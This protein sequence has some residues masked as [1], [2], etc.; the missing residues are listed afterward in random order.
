MRITASDTFEVEGVLLREVMAVNVVSLMKFAI[1]YPVNSAS[2]TPM[3]VS[4][5]ALINYASMGVRAV[6][7]GR[8]VGIIWVFPDSTNSPHPFQVKL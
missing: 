5:Q 3:Q 7:V 8:I 4:E 2:H 6:K 1:N